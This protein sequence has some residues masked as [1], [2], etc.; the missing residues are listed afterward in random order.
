MADYQEEKNNFLL[1]KG[2]EDDDTFSS[3]KSFALVYE[4]ITSSAHTE[5]IGV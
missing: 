5:R 4:K 3:Q 1:V 2:M